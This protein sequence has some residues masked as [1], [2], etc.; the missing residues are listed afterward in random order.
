MDQQV[1]TLQSKRQTKKDV[2]EATSCEKRERRHKR[3]KKEK[4]CGTI[5]D[6]LCLAP[7][8]NACEKKTVTHCFKVVLGECKVTRDVKVTHCI[9]ANLNHHIK[10]DVVCKHDPCTKYTCEEKHTVKDGKC[11]DVK[12]PDC[13]DN[14]VFVDDFE[15]CHKDK[16]CKVPKSCDKS[17]SKSSDSS[18][19][20]SSK[21]SRSSKK[22]KKSKH[23]VCVS[24]R[25]SDRRSDKRSD[26]KSDDKHCGIPQVV[27]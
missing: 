5:C 26:R 21:S 17:D 12:F 24:D 22:C 25:K 27:F 4:Q 3:C 15:D 9:T 23:E 1:E 14:I 16:K 7:P 20:S 8:E 13:D 11:C 10:E 19:R 2:F 6:R 18:S